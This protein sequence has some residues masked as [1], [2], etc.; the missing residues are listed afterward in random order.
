MKTFHSSKEY[1]LG[2]YEKAL[3]DQ[4]SLEKKI[5]ACFE[6]G[7]DFIE[8]SIDEN[9]LRLSRLGNASFEFS[10]QE[11]NKFPSINVS[12]LKT[13]CF[14]GLDETF[15]EAVSL[16]EQVISFAAEIKADTVQITAFPFSEN[17][18]FEQKKQLF[19]E[20][21]R[22]ILKTAEKRNIIVSFEKM[23]NGLLKNS[24]IAKQIIDAV[25]IVSDLQ[26]AEKEIIGCH[27]KETNPKH[28]R[29]IEFES[30]ND[31]SQYKKHFTYLKKIGC[32][33]YMAEFWDKEGSNLQRIRNVSEYLRS[34]LDEVYAC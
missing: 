7:F 4:M 27:V 34:I 25:N 3:P 18:S 33:R 19:E 1:L 15:Q 31:Y 11:K 21:L 2:L 8:L 14:S 10:S 32:K 22:R 30:G 24:K 26:L 13:F 28:E 17:I 20:F 6:T 9:P 5:S 12:T 23:N 29:R 16:M